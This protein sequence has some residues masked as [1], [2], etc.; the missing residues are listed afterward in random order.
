MYKFIVNPQTNRKV[1]VKSNHG[2]RIIKNYL[3]GG[4]KIKLSKKNSV[5]I[6]NSINNIVN[7]LIKK[8]PIQ[9]LIDNGSVSMLD[10]IKINKFINTIQ[11]K[12][13]NHTELLS[14]NSALNKNIANIL[15]FL[16]PVQNFIENFESV[17]SKKDKIKY[18]GL[19]TK[20]VIIGCLL[21]GV[22]ATSVAADPTGIT[23]AQLVSSTNA[24][25]TGALTSTSG[26]VIPTAL[27]TLT[28]NV[29]E[30]VGIA[31]LLNMTYRHPEEMDVK[32]TEKAGADGIV[33]IFD[34][35]VIKH[36]KKK[37]G[38]SDELYM[39]KA[40]SHLNINK[41]KILD[42]DDSALTI[43]YEKFKSNLVPPKGTKYV[44]SG[45]GMTPLLPITG[46]YINNDNIQGL[47]S[48][49][50]ELH[51]NFITHNDIHDGNIAIKN[52]GTLAF[53]DFGLSKIITDDTLK[54]LIGSI[55]KKNLKKFVKK[56]S[57]GSNINILDELKRLKLKYYIKKN[58]VANF[59]KILENMEN[60]EVGQECDLAQLRG[61]FLKS[62][63]PLNTKFSERLIKKILSL[64]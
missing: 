56:I 55:K 61:L 59:E 29:I 9:E 14:S 60:V 47:L 10:L 26:S 5:Y 16:E 30:S 39:G 17:I 31:S 34:T 45:C 35:Y 15:I 7:N 44:S 52:D 11:T 6:I 28:T 13:I 4:E 18:G 48:D 49:I 41:I 64:I 37:A 2:I 50:Q 3:G 12:L 62:N 51:N 22:I 54:S 36:F 40:I 8:S 23:A 21:L 20:Q 19:D 27:T 57:T 58:D 42:N 24:T 46:F 38:Y 25:L 33:R 1:N 63:I 32:F 43:T 53:N